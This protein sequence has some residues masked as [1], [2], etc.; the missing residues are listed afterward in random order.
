[1]TV[2]NLSGQKT[3]LSVLWWNVHNLRNVEHARKIIAH[4]KENNPDV[5]GLGEIV[6]E[7]AYRLIARE[8]PDY[9]F[10]MTYG[11]QSQEMLVGVRRTFQA[12]FSQKTEFQSGNE[13]LRPAALVTISVGTPALNILFVHLKSFTN[14]LSLGF[15]DDF[16]D[17]LGRLKN[18]LDNLSNGAARFI[19]CGD[20]NIQGL[21][22]LNRSYIKPVE[23]LQHI[24][25]KL[26][27]VG[28]IFAEADYEETWIDKRTETKTA[29][30]DY[31]AAT[32]ALTLV[33][34]E[35]QKCD[36]QVR[37]NGWPKYPEKSL[38]RHEFIQSISD[39]ASLY[40]EVEI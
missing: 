33:K 29:R 36:Y 10:Y 20:F 15:R 28:F 8:F 40:F 3:K 37:I 19:V 12:F 17:R 6:G 9:T 34:L 4:V 1:M 18:K 30:L 25:N 23:E 35:E 5:F 21:H 14:P 32:T 27:D 22:Y 2:S 16:F 26:G 13:F 11:K 39:H 7:D 31:V 24:Q 38:E